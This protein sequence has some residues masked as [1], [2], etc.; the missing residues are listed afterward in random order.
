MAKFVDYEITPEIE[1]IM[2]KIISTYPKVF[3]GFDVNL[4]QSFHTIGKKS[5]KPLKLIPVKYPQNIFIDKVYLIE[6]FK[7]LWADMSDKQKGLAVFHIMSAIP[8]A[9]GAFDKE[10]QNYGK[11]KR[12]DIEMYAEEFAVSGGVPNWMENPDA[13]D[14]FDHSDDNGGIKNPVTMESVSEIVEVD[15]SE[16]SE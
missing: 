9:E 1:D 8:S 15:Q 2:E 16:D 13:S 3:E 4:I 10:S 5:R 14:V 6:V 12:Y 11:K 7:E